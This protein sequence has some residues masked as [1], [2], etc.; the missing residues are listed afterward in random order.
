MKKNTSLLLALALFTAWPAQSQIQPPALRS[1]LV[2]GLS[3]YSPSTGAATLEGL[4]DHH[5]NAGN[6]GAG[7]AD[8]VDQGTGGV[9]VGKEVIDQ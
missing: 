9:A 6:T 1:A 7:L 8:Q 3:Q 4:F 2:I 5:T